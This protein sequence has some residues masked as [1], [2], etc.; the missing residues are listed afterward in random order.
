MNEKLLEDWTLRELYEYCKNGNC[1]SC[2]FYEEAGCKARIVTGKVPL[3]W[4]IDE[5]KKSEGALSEKE[6]QED[7]EKVKNF[8]NMTIEEIKDFCVNNKCKDCP[9]HEEKG[10]CKVRAYTNSMPDYW[11]A[12]VAQD[13]NIYE[14]Q[15]GKASDKTLQKLP[16]FY[17]HILIYKQILDNTQAVFGEENMTEAVMM[18]AIEAAENILTCFL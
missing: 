15:Q 16:I 8:I 12:S 10:G 14:K 2:N 1:Q 6:I 3:F 13:K 5:N 17:E 11:G 7:D 4:E 9:W 18:R